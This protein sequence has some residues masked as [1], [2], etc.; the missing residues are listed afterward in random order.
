MKKI[1]RHPITNALCIGLF[2]LFYA[3]IFFWT[4]HSDAFKAEL[5]YATDIK[6]SS[7]LENWSKILFEGQHMVLAYILLVV[8]V[9]I[10]IL[11]LI[12]KKPYD[13]Y[14]INILVNCLLIALS[15]ILI[16]IALF[17]LFVITNP[18]NIVEKFMCFISI[19]WITVVFADLFYITLS[20]R[21]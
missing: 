1:I 18:T 2:S 10:I 19:H 8:T 9:V 3:I 12:R 13:E 11:L 7:F 15:L 14:Q 21:K 5:L 4:V 16:V 20:C 17:F 6:G